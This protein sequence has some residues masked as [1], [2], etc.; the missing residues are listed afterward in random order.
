MENEEKKPPSAQ[1]AAPR[2]APPALRV[3]RPSQPGRHVVRPVASACVSIA[4][5]RSSY[6]WTPP[7]SPPTPVPLLQNCLPRISL[8]RRFHLEPHH[9][10]SFSLPLSDAQP[11]PLVPAHSAMRQ[12]RPAAMARPRCDGAA[13]LLPGTAEA[14]DRAEPLRAGPSMP[15]RPGP[16]CR[17]A[18]SS[19]FRPSSSTLVSCPHRSSLGK[20][21]SPL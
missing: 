1:S 3:R 18:V 2:H 4:R 17:R 16:L 10:I 8:P 11:P 21:I 14:A 20:A 7:T 5:L 6:A 9:P 15:I 19:L 12:G 13:G